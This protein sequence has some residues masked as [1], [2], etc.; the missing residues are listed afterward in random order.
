[1]QYTTA[2]K[3]DSTLDRFHIMCGSLLHV[4]IGVWC[5]STEITV[6]RESNKE[7]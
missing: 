6:D 5:I 2:Q 7:T 1:M 3:C 4:E